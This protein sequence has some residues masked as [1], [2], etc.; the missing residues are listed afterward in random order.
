MADPGLQDAARPYLLG[1]G[2][3]VL[4]LARVA[5]SPQPLAA[6]LMGRSLIARG[7][8]EAAVPELRRAL[9]GGLGGLLRDEARLSLGEARCQAADLDAGEEELRGLARELP[10]AADRL[11][12]EAGVR[13]CAFEREE[14][15][16]R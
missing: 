4:A 10:A 8:A 9:S 11:R 12:A 14:R 3:P 6:Y 13:R 5:R 15:A 2:D 7:E 1:L 16:R